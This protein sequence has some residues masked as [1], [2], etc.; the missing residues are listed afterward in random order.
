MSS[1]T[2]KVKNWMTRQVRIYMLRVDFKNFF[3]NILLDKKKTW[4]KG[5]KLRTCM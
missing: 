3:K 5:S 1:F 2:N 4:A